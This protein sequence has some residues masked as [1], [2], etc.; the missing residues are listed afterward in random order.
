MLNRAH[1]SHDPLD[2]ENLAFLC[3][4]CHARNDTPQRVAMTRRTRAE[5]AGQLW[6][7]EEIR[8]GPY[9]VRT[10]PENCANAAVPAGID[11]SS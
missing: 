1:L 2:P 9:P 11:I 10:W 5:R 4:S 3:P 7:D 8:L 6:L